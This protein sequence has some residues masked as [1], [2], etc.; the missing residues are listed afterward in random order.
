M[1]ISDSYLQ[2]FRSLEQMLADIG[3]NL[4]KVTLS[5]RSDYG[6]GFKQPFDNFGHYTSKI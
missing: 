5:L 2:S 3:V 6:T 4:C 1:K